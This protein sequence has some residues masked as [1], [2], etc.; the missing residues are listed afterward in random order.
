MCKTS[1]WHKTAECWWQKYSNKKN[2]YVRD[3]FHLKWTNLL[4][5]SERCWF[6]PLLS[7][8]TIAFSPPVSNENANGQRRPIWQLTILS[9]PVLVLLC[10]LPPH[11]CQT[12]LCSFLIT[13]AR[14]QSPNKPHS[15]YTGAIGRCVIWLVS[16][17]QIEWRT[18]ISIRKR[19]AASKGPR[20]AQF[21]CPQEGRIMFCVS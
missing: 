18:Y 16:E 21:R 17:S 8:N 19:L 4:F 5:H 3:L 10:L 7:T 13:C 14:I 6:F 15:R 1:E 11:N 12:N 20:E 9:N 2:M